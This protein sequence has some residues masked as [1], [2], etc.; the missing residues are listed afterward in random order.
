MKFESYAQDCEDIILYCVLKDIEKG[1]YIDVGANDPEIISV[2]KAFYDRGWHGIN[3]EPIH[4]V[5]AKLVQ[6]RPCDINLCIGCGKERGK[7]DLYERGM[8]ST[9]SSEEV[10]RQKIPESIKKTRAVWTLSEVYEQYPPPSG[11]VHFCKIDVEGYEREVLVGVKDWHKFRPW[12][13]VMEATLPG[14]FTPCHDKWESILLDNEYI[15]AFKHGINRYYVA[16]EREYLL[17]NFAKINQF[18]AEN[19]VWQRFRRKI[20]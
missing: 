9:F 7:M 14:T 10:T 20:G 2:T 15:F 5:C 19:E 18:V 8:G 12:I 13:F 1:F 6:E 11:N 3:I 16:A 4:A 17:D